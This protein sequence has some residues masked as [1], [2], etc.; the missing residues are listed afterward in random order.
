MPDRQKIA[1]SY[2]LHIALAVRVGDR[3]H[4]FRNFLD[5]WAAFSK[6][7]VHLGSGLRP[8]WLNN[9]RPWLKQF[10]A[11]HEL[12]FVSQEAARIL[13]RG[14][15]NDPTL[16]TL[17]KA[18]DKSVRV[19]VDHCVPLAELCNCLH[20]RQIN[21]PAAVK[22]FLTAWFRRGVITF[23][24]DQRLKKAGLNK[25]MPTLDWHLGSPFARY[26]AAQIE[27]A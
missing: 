5:N 19:V 18:G 4:V 12:D 10:A 26:E 27:P 23:E 15:L 7:G 16:K 2:L 17:H 25:R 8:R 11:V 9:P 1:D 21:T 14:K 22:T 24:E 6:G 3:G 20:E 13:A